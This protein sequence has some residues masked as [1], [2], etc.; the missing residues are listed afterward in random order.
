MISIITPTFNRE[1]LLQ[2]TVRSIIN[3]TY[4]DW[5][6][7]IVDDGSTDNTEQA[8]QPFL[9]DKRIRYVKKQNTGQPDSLN[10]GARFARGEFITF[11]DSD[12]EAYPPWLETVQQH[13][14]DDTG[15]VCVG[16][17]RKFPD[18]SVIEEGMNVFR[19]FGKVFHLKF[20]CGSLFIKRS[21][22]TKIGGYDAGLKSNIQTDLGYRLI[23]ELNTS[24]M[25]A[26][27][28]DNFLV[29]V[30][31]HDGPRIRTNW[32]KRKEGSIQFLHK[33][34]DFLKQND[35]RIISDTY[36]VIA[37]ACY[38]LKKRS[39]SLAYIL[40]AIRYNPVRPINYLRAIK[41]VF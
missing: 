34:F 14:K 31:V 16:A 39:E 5:E 21:L 29:Q 3:Q 8:I 18:G 32:N 36:A 13:I 15:I 6:L 35:T 41:Y 9:E 38:K 37:Y 22:F 20:T 19:F 17:M 28:V 11:L 10:H 4:T 1:I 26:V 30:N 2:T 12:D 27:V 40:K 25:Q 23:R 24:K 7:I 33:H